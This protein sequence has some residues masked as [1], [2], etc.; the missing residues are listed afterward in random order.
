MEKKYWLRRRYASSAGARRAFNSRT[1][2]ADWGYGAR[3]I[4]AASVTPFL[5]HRTAVSESEKALLAVVPEPADADATYYSQLELGAL[6]LAEQ[7]SD[8]AERDEHLRMAGIY[9]GRAR[10]A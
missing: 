6:F 5:L 2:L 7:S 10:D 3:R 1:R 8:P 9:R 4:G